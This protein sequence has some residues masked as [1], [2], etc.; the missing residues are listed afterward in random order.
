MW[1]AN[2]YLKMQ[3]KCL[4][5]E[6]KIIRQEQ[7]KHSYQ[8]LASMLGRNACQNAL[9]HG[10]PNT[11]SCQPRTRTMQ[12]WSDKSR[13]SVKQLVRSDVW[14]QQHNTRQVWSTELPV[15]ADDLN[16]VVVYFLHPTFA[17]VII[18]HSLNVCLGIIA[19]HVQHLMTTIFINLI[20]TTSLT[21]PQRPV[22]V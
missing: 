1:F 11:H 16:V 18:Y 2:S 21:G 6:R 9:N 17:H 10:N 7:G 20:S 8:L 13:F 4:V 14:H 5:D 15:Q 19:H 3:T 22:E 12:D